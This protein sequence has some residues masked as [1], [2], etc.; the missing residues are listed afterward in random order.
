[1]LNFFVG[2]KKEP[3]HKDVQFFVD[4]GIPKDRVVQVLKDFNNDA[5]KAAEYLFASN[6]GQSQAKTNG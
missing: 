4:M 3:S 5:H 6:P 1:M 2:G